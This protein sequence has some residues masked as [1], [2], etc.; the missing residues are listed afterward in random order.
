MREGSPQSAPQDLW[1]QDCLAYLDHLILERGLSAHTC[2]A[3]RS[4]LTRLCRW[5]RSKTLS[6]PAA[7]DRS[8][9]ED[10]LY[11]LTAQGLSPASVARALSS[12]RGWYRYLQ[13]TG[14]CDGDPT[15]SVKAPKPWQALPGALSLEET[16]LL[17]DPALESGPLGDRNT[18]LL[19]LMYA[20]G[21]RVSE[22]VG[23]TLDSLDLHQRLLRITGKGG[24]ERLVPVGDVAAVRVADYL[25]NARPN[26]CKGT[27]TPH[28]FITSRGGGMTRQACWHMLKKR[29]LRV[30]IVN[31]SPHTLRHTFATHLLDG[32]ADLR[33][34]Q[35]LLG[36]ADIGTTQIYTHV[37]RERLKSVHARYHP[38]G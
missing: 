36:H 38:R 35:A 8:Q 32:G 6:G 19:E 22:A 17:L 14:R 37:S 27:P 25:R 3:Y 1:Q 11:A 2:A 28:L 4:D 7:L 30:D 31:I 29:A 9:M 15:L 12:V 16:D 24:K 13:E 26:L 5:A 23:L 34:V 20:C 21:L 33:V 18:A 10:H